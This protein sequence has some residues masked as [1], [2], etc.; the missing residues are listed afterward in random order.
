MAKA[1]KKKS[2]TEALLFIQNGYLCTAMKKLIIFDLDGTLLNTIDDL[3]MA[4]NHA[5]AENGYPTHAVEEYNFFV[6]NGI[7]KLFER[8]LPEEART[9]ENVQRI[10]ASFIPFYDAH[11]LDLTR[12][13]DGIPEL[14][15]TLSDNGVKLAIASNKYQLAT[16]KLVNY[17][18]AETPF[19]AVF[20]QRENVPIK[21]D[22][23]VV[24][25]IRRLAKA[26][27]AETLFVG[28][29]GVDMLTAQ[30]AGVTAVGVTWGFRSAEELRTYDPDYLVAKPDE[31]RF[32]L[33]L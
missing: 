3:A 32:L 8:A 30:Q 33:G 7:N 24:E 20:G 22:P 2:P 13:Y 9:P 27:P 23:T 18:F 14:L 6:G 31:I 10:R 26:E 29:S 21:P 4:T 28:D 11:K 25:E 5:L 15:K 16:E 19:V 1:S 12:P 17:Y